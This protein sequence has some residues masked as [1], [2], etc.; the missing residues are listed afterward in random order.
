MHIMHLIFDVIH[1]LY[2]NLN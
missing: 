2:K 1:Y